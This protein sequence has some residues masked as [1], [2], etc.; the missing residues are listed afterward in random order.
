MSLTL[1]ERLPGRNS[2]CIYFPTHSFIRNAG[3]TNLY[4]VSLN[5]L[6]SR[7]EDCSHELLCL[8]LS[9]SYLISYKLKILELEGSYSVSLM[10][11]FVN[12]LKTK[13]L[14]RVCWYT[15]NSSPQKAEAGRS[16]S[17][18]SA[19]STKR[20]PVQP[21]YTE[22]PVLKNK[23]QTKPNQNKTKNKQNKTKKPLPAWVLCR[24]TRVHTHSAGRP[25]GVPKKNK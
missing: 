18:R 6:Y 23:Q 20:V 8:L 22:N 4:S 1:R 14:A 15:F 3:L 13:T 5:S 25:C 17:S 10:E 21:C 2:G 19:W 24:F 11:R 9:F 7:C 12:L 16:L